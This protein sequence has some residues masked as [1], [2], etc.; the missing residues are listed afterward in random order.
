MTQST[1]VLLA[2]TLSLAA[3]ACTN[4]AD[5]KPKAKVGEATPAEPAATP[6]KG[7]FAVDPSKSKLGFIGSK[8]T[9][10]HEGGFKTFE[11]TVSPKGGKV[12]GGSVSVEIDVGS[13]FTDSEKLT[14]HLQGADFFD[15][16][17]HPKATF[18]STAIDVGDSK[19][20][21]HSVTGN[22]ELHGVKKSI[23]FPAN[24]VQDRGTLKVESEFS[25]NRKDFDMEYAGMPDD[26]IRD[27]VVIKLDLVFTS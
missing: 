8:V 12:E 4:P 6:T 14:G 9:G 20:Y 23:T 7:A 16:E 19:E 21:S 26:L 1:S 15:V 18:V 11:A 3:T 13:M 22:L 25:I 10:S 5:D 24:I 27:E 2:L 17:A